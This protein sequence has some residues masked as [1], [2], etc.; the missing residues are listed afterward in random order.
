M[1]GLCQFE[2]MALTYF[3]TEI[4]RFLKSLLLIEGDRDFDRQRIINSRTQKQIPQ[5]GRPFRELYPGSLTHLRQLPGRHVR[6]DE[7]HIFAKLKA[8]HK[9]RGCYQDN[10]VRWKVSH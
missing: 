9:K 3:R 1:A 7:F 8:P 10:R 2:S 5:A 4:V 6:G